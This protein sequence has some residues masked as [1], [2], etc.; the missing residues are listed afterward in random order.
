MLNEDCFENSKNPLVRILVGRLA[1]RTVLCALTYLSP[2]FS[3]HVSYFFTQ[4]FLPLWMGLV[5]RRSRLG[6]GGPERPGLC[7]LC[8]LES[9][10]VLTLPSRKHETKRGTS[11]PS[12]CHLPRCFLTAFP[13][14]LR[15]LLSVGC[16]FPSGA[17]SYLPVFWGNFPFP[18]LSTEPFL[19]VP[20]L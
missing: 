1:F 3:D 15:V 11:P 13:R 2:A 14:L 8:C 9:W 20:D 7:G 17:L 5:F 6:S 10:S 12:P 19:K 18:R 4:H 16:A